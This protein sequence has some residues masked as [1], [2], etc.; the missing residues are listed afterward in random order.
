MR[1]A[2]G[3][4]ARLGHRR[5]GLISAAPD[6]VLTRDRVRGYR[7]AVDAH[8][9]VRDDGFVA[10][11]DYYGAEAARVLARELLSRRESERPTA[12]IADSVMAPGVYDAAAELGMSIPA[13]LAVVGYDEAPE[14]RA[15]HPRLTTVRTSHYEIG[16][17]AAELLLDQICGRTRA[18]RQLVVDPVLEI[19][20][21]CGAQPAPRAD[22]QVGPPSA[23]VRR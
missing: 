13:R 3:H 12:L 15:L 6:M 22:S 2:V 19:R 7:A 18:P 4:L 5:I 8:E 20:A 10:L 17:A 14:A 21:S 1:L 23:G 11:A 16:A 9:L